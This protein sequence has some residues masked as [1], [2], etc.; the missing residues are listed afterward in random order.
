M[1]LEGSGVSPPVP[2]KAWAR[3]PMQGPRQ[4]AAAVP[5]GLGGHGVAFLHSPPSHVQVPAFRWAWREGTYRTPLLRLKALTSGPTPQPRVGPGSSREEEGVCMHMCVRVVVC[6]HVSLCTHTWVVICAHVCTRAQVC[7]CMYTW[8]CA[9]DCVWLCA[10]TRMCVC[11]QVCGYMC[12][13]A[14]RY[15]DACTHVMCTRLCVVVRMHVCVCMQVCGYLHTCARV[16]THV[17][18]H[19]YGCVR[20]HLCVVVCTRVVLCTCACVWLCACM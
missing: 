14:H 9:C 18:A 11:M 5:C 13:H 1:S 7:G 4:R 12:A 15:A 6:M 10:C 3:P 8:P 20:T 2:A 16:P 19:I 17:D